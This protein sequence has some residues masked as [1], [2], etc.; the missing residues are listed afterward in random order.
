MSRNQASVRKNEIMIVFTISLASFMGTLDVSIVNISLPT[1]ARSFQVSTGSVS[2]VILAYLLIIS[3]FLPAFGRLGDIKGFRKIFIGGFSTFGVGSFCC[4]AALNFPE[5]IA[6][7][8]IQASGAAMLS[9]IGP[10]MVIAYLP[11]KIRGQAMGYVTTFASLGIAVGP[12]AGGFV[13][14]YLSWRWIFFINVPV[15]VAGLLLGLVFLPRVKPDSPDKKFDLPGAILIFLSLFALLYGLNMGGEAGWAS[16]RILGA[17]ALAILFGGVFLWR[18]ARIPDP[19]ISLKIFHST[20]FTLGNIS[21]G[22][23]MVVFT[24]ALFLLP[25]YLELGRKLSVVRAGMILLVPSVIMMISS[26]ISGHISDR[27]G[28]RGICLFASCVMAIAFFLLSLLGDVSA[29]WFLLLALVLM[30]A[31]VGIFIPP[32]NSLILGNCPPDTEGI[33]SSVMMTIRNGGAVLGVAIFET[34]FAGTVGT[35]T[36]EKIY[37]GISNALLMSGFH[38]AFLAGAGIAFL[39]FLLFWG[40]KARR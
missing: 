33:S 5:L 9:A 13:T 10:S 25:F 3:S 11:D 24:G 15:A 26:P 31:G 38:R 30:G 17:F 18:E 28:S 21:G 32:V 23:M 29:L 16:R 40:V 12:V 36:G 4:G 27:L 34:I 1:I 35:N 8:I 7:R 19:L 37:S 20:S 22:M 14:Q 6:A 2:W 39:A